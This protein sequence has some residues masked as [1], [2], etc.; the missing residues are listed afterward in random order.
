MLRDLFHSYIK[1]YI[2][3]YQSKSTQVNPGVN[4]IMQA[5]RG[6]KWTVMISYQ[7]SLSQIRVQPDYYL[8]DNT[9]CL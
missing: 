4:T 8:V 2:Y 6:G 9:G 7:I 1:R 5:P 3:I